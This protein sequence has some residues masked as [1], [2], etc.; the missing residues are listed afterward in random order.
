M[1]RFKTFALDEND[2]RFP[3][4]FCDIKLSNLHR[5]LVEVFKHQIHEKEGK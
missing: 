1:N 2:K 4:K 3:F 5:G